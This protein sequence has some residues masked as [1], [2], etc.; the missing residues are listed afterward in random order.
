[1]LLWLDIVIMLNEMSGMV[2]FLVSTVL[3]LWFSLFDVL[4]GRLHGVKDIRLW[5]KNECFRSHFLF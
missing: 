3:F 2:C 5:G 1:M 4:S